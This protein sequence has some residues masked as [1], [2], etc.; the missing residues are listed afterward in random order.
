MKAYRAAL[1]GCGGRGRPHLQAYEHLNEGRAVACC[2][3]VPERAENLAAEF[4]INAYADAAE[5][6]TA[7]K[8]DIVH[9][10]T[11]PDARVELM[12]LVSDMRLPLCTVEKPIATGP[13]DWRQLVELEAGSPTRFAV[14]H[15]FRWHPNFVKC[16]EALRSGKLGEVKFLDFSAGMNI[17]GQGTHVLNYGLSLNGDSPVARVFG[18]ASG[19]SEMDSVHPAPDTTVGY[20]TFENG[21]R[22]LW[23]N[24]HTAPRVGDPTTDWQHVRAAAYADRGRVLWEEFGRW[25]VISPDGIE[26]GTFG[27]MEAWM[28]DNL[29]AQAAFYRAMFD[30]LEGGA[31]PGTHLKQSLHEWQVVLALYM[32][33]ISREPIEIA[34]FDPPDNLFE[35]L[36]AVVA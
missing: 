22:G 31:A 19:G 23:N 11:P 18:A 17:S 28:P 20:L 7:E 21:V 36:A 27:G 29:R 4:G 30:W 15:Q 16:R 3:R 8:P 2:D 9:I 34:E 33:A 1:I 6:L 10:A 14:C 5:M 35:Q 12:T 32:S 25:E 13:R 26:S 24:G